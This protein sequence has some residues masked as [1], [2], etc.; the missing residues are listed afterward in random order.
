[1]ENTSN[2]TPRRPVRRRRKRNPVR[3]FIQS[4]LPV[5]VVAVLVILFI[6]FVSGSISRSNARREQKRQESI[7]AEQSEAQ[8]ELEL[9]A[10]A[11]RLAA[12]AEVLAAMYDYDGAVA[13]LD[14]FSGNLYDYDAMLES[15]D[16][17]LAAKDT[18]VAWDDP[19]KVTSLSFHHLIVDGHRAFSDPEDGSG[20][21]YHYLTI[22]EFTA[23]LQQLYDNGYVLVDLDDFIAA[24]N[25]A[26]GISG[27][28]P[29]TLYLPEG[30]KPLLLSQNQV[31]YY[32][33]LIDGN[34]DGLPDKDGDG[35]ASRLVVDSNGNLACEYMDSNG[36]VQTGAYDLVPVLEE[37]I[38]RNPGFSYRGARAILAVSGYEGLF[39][40]RTNPEAADALGQ[41][42]YDEQ[43]A[44][45]PKVLNA[46]REKGYTIA[47]Y[48]YGNVA[49]GKL[50]A[51][52]IKEDLDKWKAEVTPL[53]GETDIL[54][55]AKTSDISDTHEAYSGD[56]Y[57]VLRDMGLRCFLGFGNAP[58]ATVSNDS[59]R[60]GRLLVTGNNLKNNASLFEGLFD[61][62]SVLDT[63]R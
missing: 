33:Y 44:Q 14:S 29:K 47:C 40:Y 30:K 56:K 16:A 20:Y 49:Y 26:D 43:L 54:V 2:G 15:R 62:A 59:V 58:W 10:E 39:G 42:Y 25:S 8:Y 41:D 52:E 3:V 11:N 6:I 61:A 27:Y 7:A 17:Y 53:L 5:L 57:N 51:A 45:L 19:S 36:N 46:L 4:Y 12:E 60:L 32:A 1:M 35:F 24:P 38:A 23:I 21:Q 22:K 55:L 34:D 48:T 63:S 37:F 31:N 50:S 18:L 9:H 13:V 28:S